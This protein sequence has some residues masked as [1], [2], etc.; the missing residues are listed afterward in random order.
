MLCSINW[1][2][3]NW[4]ILGWILWGYLILIRSILAI[5]IRWYIL[6]WNYLAWIPWISDVWL[7]RNAWNWITTWINWNNIAVLS[8][9]YGNFI[10]RGIFINRC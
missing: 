4:R 9:S 5:W 7:F 6:I 2:V 3:N 10:A 1:S 8:I